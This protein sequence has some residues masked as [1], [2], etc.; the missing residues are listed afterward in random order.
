MSNIESKNQLPLAIQAYEK[1]RKQR[2]DQIQAAA[3]QAKEQ[4]HL[5][6]EKAQVARDNQRKAASGA[7]QNSDI[8]KMQH[9]YWVWDAA[10]VARSALIDL[11]KAEKAS[12]P[13]DRVLPMGLT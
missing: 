7:N 1:S 2:V 11:I 6:D 5:K 3:Y 13:L 8:V 9:S 12:K 10:E 4:L